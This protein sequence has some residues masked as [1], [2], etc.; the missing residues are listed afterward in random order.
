MKRYF[1]EF[2]HIIILRSLSL[3]KTYRIFILGLLLF[4]V[5]LLVSCNKTTAAGAE[6]EAFTST[7]ETLPAETVAETEPVE[8]E[9]PYDL[10]VDP[11]YY[12]ALPDIEY[13]LSEN[14]AERSCAFD[15]SGTLRSSSGTS[16]NIVVEWQAIREEGEDYAVLKLDVATEHKAIHAK[17]FIGTLKVNGEE[18][19]FM[20]PYYD[21]DHRL[22]TRDWLCP[23]E[24]VIPCGYGE[25]AVVNIDIKWDFNGIYEGKKFTD[26]ISL[27]AKLPIS[28]KYGALKESI[29]LDVKNILQEPELP[30]GCEVTSLA[31]L[32]GYLGFDITHTDL[33]DNYLP[34]GEVGKVTPYE[35]NLGNPRERGKSWG[36]YSPVIVKTANKYLAK[37][38]S[39]YRAFD[40]TGYDMSKLLHQVS[41]G[42]PAIVW[43][44]M[45]FADP[46]VKKPWNINGEPF[47]WKYPL[48]CV[49]ISGY[50]L[51][52]NT[53]TLTDPLKKAPVTVDMD[54]FMLRWHQIGSQAVVIKE[55][56]ALNVPPPG[57][58]DDSKVWS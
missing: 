5:S 48:H 15:I 3:K 52:A 19:F 42:N 58:P 14:K 57:I 16:L 29:K 22:F 18:H 43:V 24:T 28:E 8:T 34:Q 30:E 21:T 49:V 6:T 40:Y 25:E 56:R 10:S 1:V 13:G 31:I 36:C 46:Y 45:N 2:V 41:L 20:S 23:V 37:Q 32:L 12:E 11:A 35:M 9:D 44:T 26:G 17:N 51:A 33:A 27:K 39:Y 53:V 54:T 55:S 4:L 7:A 38:R 50:D 47:Y